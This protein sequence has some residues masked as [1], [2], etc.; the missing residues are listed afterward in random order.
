MDKEFKNGRLFLHR[1]EEERTPILLRIA[2]IEGQLRGVKQMVEG[3]RYCGDKV[4]QILAILAATKEVMRVIVAQH[5]TAGIEFALEGE[6]STT[7]VMAD[8][9]KVLRSLIRNH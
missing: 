4:Q 1:T 8:I 3:D 2:K 5:V 9:D 7:D 6:A